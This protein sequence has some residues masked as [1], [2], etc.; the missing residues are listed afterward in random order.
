MAI[1]WKEFPEI[2]R[3]VAFTTYV[4]GIGGSLGCHCGTISGVNLSFG[5]RYNQA[6]HGKD[7]EVLDTTK[8]PQFEYRRDV[9]TNNWAP[10]S[11]EKLKVHEFLKKLKLKFEDFGA[12]VYI[13]LIEQCKNLPLWVMSDVINKEA[14]QRKIKGPTG[15]S[16]VFGSTRGFAKYLIDNKIGY[17]LASPIVQNPSHRMVGNY[18]LNQAWFWI[19]PQHISRSINVAKIYGANQFLDKKDWSEIVGKDLCIPKDEVFKAVLESGVFPEP[20]F[21]RSAN[22]RFAKI[23]EA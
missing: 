4:D 2:N 17:M 22:G 15:D 13:K 16:I 10:P 6:N 20:R 9:F 11:D 7:I 3:K 14:P 1:L 12:E 5:G 18:S 23:S 21:K 19:P 8:E